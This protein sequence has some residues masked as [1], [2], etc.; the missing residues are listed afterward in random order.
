M[1]LEGHHYYERI[2]YD[3]DDHE[4]DPILPSFGSFINGLSQVSSRQEIDQ[5][6][7]GNE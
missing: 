5:K 6:N 7:I 3:T 2:K 1:A 4:A